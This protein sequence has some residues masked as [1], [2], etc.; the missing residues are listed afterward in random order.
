MEMAGQ[1][2][3]GLERLQ[4]QG[5]DPELGNLPESTEEN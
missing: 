2:A 4:T 1:D 5:G 3:T